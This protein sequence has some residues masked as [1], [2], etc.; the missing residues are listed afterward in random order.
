M[1]TKAAISIRRQTAI[2]RIANALNVDLSVQ[3][4]DPD[5]ATAILLERIADAVEA[6]PEPEPTPK[7]RKT[8]KAKSE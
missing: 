1:A 7:T 3:S 6:Q 8:T 4:R 5:M 2:E